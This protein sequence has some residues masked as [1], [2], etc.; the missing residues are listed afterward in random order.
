VKRGKAG[1]AVIKMLKETEK[2][3]SKEDERNKLAAKIQEVAKGVSAQFD[4][5]GGGIRGGYAFTRYI[6]GALQD[7][8]SRIFG[9]I[10]SVF[11]SNRRL[12]AVIKRQAKT[13]NYE[14][15]NAD[16]SKKKKAV[17]SEL[18]CAIVKTAQAAVAIDE[19]NQAAKA[20]GQPKL[21]PSTITDETIADWTK[22]HKIIDINEKVTTPS[23]FAHTLVHKLGYHVARVI[24]PEDVISAE[25]WV[26]RRQAAEG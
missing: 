12:V 18:A 23:A 7:F 10:H 25:R 19:A 2:D 1:I 22:K 16:G 8:S 13:G 15:L 14:L 9:T 20:I 21:D 24:K 3:K 4:P 17:C 26:Q 6:K 5:E 11:G